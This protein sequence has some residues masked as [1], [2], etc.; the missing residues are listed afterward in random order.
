MPRWNNLG[1]LQRLLEKVVSGTPLNKHERSHLGHM[2]ATHE[3]QEEPFKWD[4]PGKH[5]HL[6]KPWKD[7]PIVAIH[8][9][10]FEAHG[11]GDEVRS[12]HSSSRGEDRAYVLTTHLCCSAPELNSAQLCNMC[13]CCLFLC[14]CCLCLCSARAQLWSRV[15]LCNVFLPPCTSE[16]FHF[17]RHLP[18]TLIIVYVPAWTQITPFN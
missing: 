10:P 15:Q 9:N 17:L 2:S 16:P 4:S 18:P 6:T 5:T 7:G 13:L 8:W 1:L 12:R 3:F 11:A 14:L